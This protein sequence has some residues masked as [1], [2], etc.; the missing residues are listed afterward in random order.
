MN[1][2]KCKENLLDDIYNND[3]EDDTFAMTCYIT[4]SKE[5]RQLLGNG[6]SDQQMVEDAKEYLDLCY[7]SETDS[8]RYAVER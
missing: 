3:L 6:T 4:M 5:A 8:L 2:R 1:I 7:R